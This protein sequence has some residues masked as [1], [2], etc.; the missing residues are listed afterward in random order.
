M[1]S[2]RSTGKMGATC[3]GRRSRTWCS[4]AL[5]PP[6]KRAPLRHCPCGQKRENRGTG[7]RQL[8]TCVGL[9]ALRR[10]WWGNRCTCA[11]A[12]GYQLDACL[13][14]DSYLNND[15][16]ANAQRAGRMREKAQLADNVQIGRASCRER[17]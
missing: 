14:L 3:S 4:S 17:V 9:L 8:M 16:K 13:G 1:P 6:K 12:A 10:H 2:K 5:M 7:S 15:V 11:V